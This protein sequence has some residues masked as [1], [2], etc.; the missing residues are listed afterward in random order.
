[1]I[2]SRNYNQLCAFVAVAQALS[3]SRAAEALGVSRS[4]LS[5]MIRKL[6]Q[7][8][9]IRLLHRTT[10]DVSL[11]DSGDALL[12]RIQPA[13]MDLGMAVEQLFPPFKPEDR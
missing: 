6:E 5:Q 1:M 2:T 8:A 12:R 7:G 11:T 9:G 3:F 13:F 4:A 10:R